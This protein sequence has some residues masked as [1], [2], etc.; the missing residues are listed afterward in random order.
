VVFPSA[1]GHNPGMTVVLTGHGL[2]LAEVVSVARDDTA[3]SIDPGAVERM[4]AA[5]AVV[6]RSLAR[7]DEVYGLTTRLGAGKTN[8]IEPSEAAA[9]QWRFVRSHLFGQG[10]VFARDVVRAA[11]L[12]LSNGFAAGWSGVRPELVSHLIEALNRRELP[13]VHSLGSVGQADLAALAELAVGVLDGVALAPGEALALLSSNAFATGHGAL[14]ISDVGAVLDALDA[15]GAL[16]LE[17]FGAN[18][19]MLHPSVAAT[20]PF[21]GLRTSLDG[22][23]RQLDG[24]A[25]WSEGASRS[26]QDP[27]TFRG[28]PQV[29]GA[30]R[31]AHTFATTQVGIELNA[32]QTNPLVVVEEGR[33]VSVANFDAQPLATAMDVVRIGLGP[34]VLASSERA[35]KLLDASWSGL[36]RGLVVGAS[37]GLSYLGI[38]AQSFASEAALLAAPASLA[39]ASTAHAEGI[40]DRAAFAALAARRVDAMA[41]LAARVVAIELVVAAQAIEMRGASDASGVGRLLE[42][43]RERVP[44]A[45]AD[46]PDPPELEPV[47]DLVRSGV[48]SMPLDRIA[49][50]I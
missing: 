22:L 19:G 18:L 31:D 13:E 46:R 26:L 20:R 49:R 2:T 12:V 37:D 30:A 41:D 27:L 47:V 45:T 11:A 29:N 33:V 7:G 21:P 43:I 40:E 6:E 50:D 48:L 28:L 9:M 44:P 24:S 35:V 5:R 14:A 42:L 8:M 32:S 3:V 23:R 10:P 15:S 38:A 16:S 25:L 1:T 4:T 17:A 34:A 36:P 39:L